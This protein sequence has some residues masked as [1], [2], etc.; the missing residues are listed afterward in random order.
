MSRRRL[1]SEID[2]PEATLRAIDSVC[3]LTLGRVLVACIDLESQGVEAVQTLPEL[4]DDGATWDQHSMSQRLCDTAE[5]MAPERTSTAQGWSSMTH[6]LV[7]VVCREGRAVPARSEFRWLN[8]WRF[9]NQL[10]CAF[11]GDRY[12]VTPHGWTGVLDA[13]ADQEPRSRPHLELL[14]A[15]EG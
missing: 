8:A 10:T 4:P 11:N 7:T 13:R 5:S 15:A 2:D 9:S 12:V 1:L 6:V 3:P 14:G